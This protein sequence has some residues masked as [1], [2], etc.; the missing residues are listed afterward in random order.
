MFKSGCLQARLTDANLKILII[1]EFTNDWL[2]T[3]W[4]RR[5]EV[6]LRKLG[7]LLVLD[8]YNEHLTPEIKTSISSINMNPVVITSGSDITPADIRCFG[9]QVIEYHL[10][11]L[12]SGWLLTEHHTL[13]PDGRIKNPN[14]FLC[15]PII[16]ALQRIS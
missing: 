3:A 14:V 7:M 16:T 13:I 5:A 11:Q 15:Q 9:Q 1:L 10:N 4:K 12:Y 8:V 6:L 2:A